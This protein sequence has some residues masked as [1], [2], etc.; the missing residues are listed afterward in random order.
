M[1]MMMVSSE[2]HYMIVVD[3]DDDDDGWEECKIV[4][5][6]FSFLFLGLKD[7]IW[8][9]RWNNGCMFWEQQC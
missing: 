2:A 9:V 3:D 7:L 8:L 6:L 1:M 5:S 4:V